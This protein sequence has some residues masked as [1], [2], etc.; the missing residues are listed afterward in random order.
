MVGGT[1]FTGGRGSVLGTLAGVLL[2]QV[3]STMALLL[4]LSIQTQFIIKGV[5]ILAAV[6]LYSLARAD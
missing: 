2:I 5:V 6:A 1:L 3:L 4:G